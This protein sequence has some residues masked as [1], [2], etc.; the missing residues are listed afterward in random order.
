MA[1]ISHSPRH[2]D[3][4]DSGE[5]LL[6]QLFSVLSNP[7]YQSSKIPWKER[8]LPTSFFL[9][10][11]DP[12]EVYNSNSAAI[13][14]AYSKSVPVNMAH[15]R[16]PYQKQQ[17]AA[18]LWGP[19]TLPVTNSYAQAQISEHPVA[20]KS[21]EA[22]FQGP[23][24]YPGF[25]DQKQQS[26]QPQIPSHSH[27]QHAKQHSLPYVV[28]HRRNP[29]TIKQTKVSN[30][31][32]SN[33]PSHEI[34]HKTYT[35]PNTQSSMCQQWTGSQPNLWNSQDCQESYGESSV[36]QGYTADWNS[37]HPNNSWSPAA[38]N[39]AV[40][41]WSPTVA[42]NAPE[43]EKIQPAQ[44][45]STAPTDKER[46]ELMFYAQ[47]LRDERE[48]LKSKVSELDKTLEAV[49]SAL[50]VEP[51]PSQPVNNGYFHQNDVT[52]NADELVP[53]I[54]PVGGNAQAASTSHVEGNTISWI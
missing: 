22:Y 37:I 53:S 13:S 26:Y 4:K 2:L 38:A 30:E 5:V 24:N 54:D 7:N 49:M 12:V 8:K 25:Y 10:P 41:S 42:A 44:S 1:E 16:P 31:W 27:I 28:P 11:Q 36:S 34:N 32:W 51:N 47:K 21:S 52:S 45:V 40:N 14:H 35:H 3:I 23:S 17:P 15:A 50:T 19:S 9:P 29:N 33:G 20:S 48:R 43:S 18:N 6:N 46:Q 39:G